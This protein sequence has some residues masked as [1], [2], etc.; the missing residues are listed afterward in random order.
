M[1]T[2]RGNN[3]FLGEEDLDVSN[4]DRLHGS[5]LGIGGIHTKSEAAVG[6]R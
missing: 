2:S 5:S 1:F 3:E 6:K 4:L